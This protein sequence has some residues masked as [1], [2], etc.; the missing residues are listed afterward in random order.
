M[1]KRKKV[2]IGLSGGVD[3]SVAAVLL[4]EAGFKVVGFHIHLWSEGSGFTKIKD[5]KKRIITTLCDDLPS[6]NRCCGGELLERARKAAFV[7]GIPFYEI[8]LRDWFYKKVVEYFLREIKKGRTP[9]PCVVCNEKVRFGK[10]LEI[11]EKELGCDFLATGHY[12]RIFTNSSAGPAAYFPRRTS[13]LTLRSLRRGSPMRVTRAK[14][15]VVYS[16]LQARDTKKDQSYFLYRLTQEQLSKLIFPLGELTK[17]EVRKL[18]K[19]Y[20]LP[21]ADA[22]ESMELCFA[23]RSYGKFLKERAPEAIKPG[24]VV[25]FDG[26]VLGRHKGLGLYTI[27]QRRGWEQ[28]ITNYKLKIKNDGD[29]FGENRK[30]LYVVRKDV[31]HNILIVGKREECMRKKFEMEDVNWIDPKFKVQSSEFRVFVKIRSQGKLN[32][33]KLEDS[34]GGKMT[35]IL[36]K[37]VFGVTPGQSAVFYERLQTTDLPVRQA[38]Y[39]LQLEICPFM[40]RGVNNGWRFF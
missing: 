30:P 17:K 28:K 33:C 38:G 5:D 35:V 40:D 7:L 3:S 39:R 21:T 29:L 34:G 8:D 18:A 15:K 10:M 25:T 27:G 26:L 16:L 1:D 24:E 14:G 11:V 13:S 9:S 6:E 20:N 36:D 37:P 23:G 2:A 4:V 31:K 32:S 19:K 12:A 22:P